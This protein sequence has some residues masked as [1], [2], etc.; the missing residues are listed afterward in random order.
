MHLNMAKI[1]FLMD[2]PI[3]REEFYYFPR[4]EPEPPLTMHLAGVS[5]C[6]GSYRI[7]REPGEVFVFEYVEAGDGFLEVEGR[8]WHPG[9]GDVY[10]APGR[11]RHAYGSGAD[12]PWV[13]YWFNLSGPLVEGLIHIYRLE[14]SFYFP[15][16]AEAGAIIKSTVEA[17][18]DLGNRDGTELVSDGFTRLIRALARHPAAAAAEAPPLRAEAEKM[19]AYLLEHLRG[20]IPPVAELGGRIKRSGVQ[21]GRIFKQSF[22]VPPH[23]F[24]LD[25]KMLAA[26]EL[27]SHSQHSVK[28]IAAWLGFADEFYFSRL[29]KRKTGLAP[30]DWRA[31]ARR[32]K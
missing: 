24:L 12:R 3:M 5:Y 1:A 18:R 17:L 8:T 22:G 30:S 2:N 14:E 20:D 6:D 31:A 32:E 26:R 9:P 28:E 23:Q 19:R 13:K 7:A 27:L 10:L 29:F 11:R 15:A 25:R 4:P 16:A 21:A